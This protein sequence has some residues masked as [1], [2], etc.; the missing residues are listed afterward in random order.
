MSYLDRLRPNI[1]LVSPS[2]LEFVAKWIGNERSKEKR[3]GIFSY[4]KVRGVVAQDLNRGGVDYPLR[5]FFDGPDN[6][7][8]AERFFTAW[9]ELG[10]WQITHPTKGAKT[11][12]PIAISEQIEPVQAG[13][14][15]VFVT[16]WIEAEPD[17]TVLSSSQISEEVLDDAQESQTEAIQQLEDEANQ[18]TESAINSIRS[19]VEKGLSKYEEF[20]QDFVELSSEI[21]AVINSVRLGIQN[22]LSTSPLDLQVLG[23]QIQT[24]M[25][26]PA[27]IEADLARAIEPYQKFI[28]SFSNDLPSGNTVEVKNET[29]AAEI[30]LSGAAIGMA[31]AAVNNPATNR[32]QALTAIDSVSAAFEQ[33]TDALDDVQE[34]YAAELL[35]EQYFSQ[36]RSFVLTAQTVVGSVAFLLRSLFDLAAE[37][38]FI[39]R[40][41]KSPI[42]I[43]IE[44]YGTLGEDDV[45]YDFFLSTNDLHGNDILLLDAGREVVIYVG[46]GS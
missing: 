42:Q 28:D 30:F 40:Q 23:A 43:T 25:N 19:G 46:G 2:G 3:V 13:N 11:L 37:K 22:A 6:D 39:L 31:Q 1:I 35:S 33:L 9:D 45:N 26:L 4:P 21:N 44:E 7:L 8:E 15:T 18:D 24:I 17:A 12:Q 10:V 34:L 16:R 32:S 36:S 14:V 5:F 27:N 29:L 38:R 20:M 41:A